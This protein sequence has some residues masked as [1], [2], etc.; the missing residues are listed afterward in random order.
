MK[1]NV[2]KILLYAFLIGV[3]PF[4]IAIAAALMTRDAVKRKREKESGTETTEP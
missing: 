3:C 1:F 4:G 2:P